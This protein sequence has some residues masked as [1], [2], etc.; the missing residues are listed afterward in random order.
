[1]DIF[2]KLYLHTEKA[3][4]IHRLFEQCNL[5]EEL[6]T[7]D[8][9][10]DY[11]SCSFMF[12]WDVKC[13]CNSLNYPS[14]IHRAPFLK[15]CVHSMIWD[16]AEVG[17]LQYWVKWYVSQQNFCLHF[18]QI[19]VNVR[20]DTKHSSSF[21][22]PSHRPRQYTKVIKNNIPHIPHCLWAI[23]NIHEPWRI[24][25]LNLYN[26]PYFFIQTWRIFLFYLTSLSCCFIFS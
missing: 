19:P 6:S 18:H 13:V 3:V 20:E 14:D 22:T 2:E 16:E 9:Y 25:R 17:G 24:L 5:K 11:L 4:H 26:L 15:I 1:M 7:L 8:R 10:S 21:S 12:S 23:G